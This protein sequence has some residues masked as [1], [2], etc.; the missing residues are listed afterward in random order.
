[1][2]SLGICS[3]SVVVAE[4]NHK[5]P[6]FVFWYRKSKK[7]L[8]LSKLAMTDMPKGRGRKGGRAPR[9]RKKPQPVTT[10]VPLMP[11]VS[12]QQSPWI[13]PKRPCQSHSSP[14]PNSETGPACSASSS[15]LP[16]CTSSA[17]PHEPSDSFT[18]TF[19]TTCPSQSQP[20]LAFTSFT[21]AHPLQQ[22]L[23]PNVQP[24]YPKISTSTDLCL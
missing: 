2:R 9:K 10:R 19:A 14:P 1:M 8:S 20:T 18:S 12:S 22:M 5:L 21:A 7:L 15:T 16:T 17:H 3:H 11:A 6:Q 4:V 24:H 23:D 13:S